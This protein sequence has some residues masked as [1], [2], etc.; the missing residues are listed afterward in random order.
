MSRP[1]KNK[2]RWMDDRQIKKIEDT[3]G[4]RVIILSAAYLMDEFD[5]S[6]EAI[7]EYWEGMLRY[8]DAIDKKL[9]TIDKVCEIIETHTGLHFQRH[10]GK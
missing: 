8:M 9:I 1:K 6:E 10:G 2:Y 3:I 7:V 4:Q 5:Y